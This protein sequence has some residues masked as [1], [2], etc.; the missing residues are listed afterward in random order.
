MKMDRRDFLKYVSAGL[1]ALA[2]RP[3]YQE[4][5]PALEDRVI[6]GGSGKVVRVATTNV[7][8]YKEPWD[9]SQIMYQRFR[10]DLLNVY[11]EV[12][13]EHGPGYNPKWYRVWG[14]YVHSAYL[15]EVETHLNEVDYSVNERPLPGTLAE[16][17]VPFT[18]AYLNRT[19][20]KWEEIFKLAYQS[21]YW[22]TAVT[23]GPDGR[24]HYRLKDASIDFD[25]M[26]YYVPA[27]HLRIIPEYELYPITP[28][29][30]VENKR[31]EVS[32][33]RQEMTCYEYDTP[34]KTLKVST[35]IPSAKRPGVI[36]TSTPTGEFN[37]INKVPSHHMGEGQITADPEAYELP[38]TPWVCY[39]EPKT[40]IAFHGAYW[41]NNFGMAMSHGCVN[42][43][44]NESKWLFRW[45]RPNIFSDMKRENT[46]FGTKVIV[47]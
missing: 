46:G 47:S 44:V 27:E 7:S 29:I 4:N 10:N 34:I 41:H 33:S 16:V 2:F 3:F 19:G 37:I 38:G 30:P 9:E 5:E 18:Q 31:I 39:F 25:T 28:E 45:A 24:P 8:I 40:G 43:P 35:G 36:P 13:S 14:G 17:T 1:G 6:L 15:Q 26:D 12:N 23:L 21:V 20:K 32:I 11:F 42:M 22:V